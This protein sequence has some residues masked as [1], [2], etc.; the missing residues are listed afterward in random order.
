MSRQGFWKLLKSYAVKAGIEKEI[1]PRMFRHSCAAHMASNGAKLGTIQEM[2]G[3]TDPTATE[4]YAGFQQETKTE[5][6]RV[7]PRG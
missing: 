6:S 5:Y 3:Y 4:I 1:T 7:H 2:L